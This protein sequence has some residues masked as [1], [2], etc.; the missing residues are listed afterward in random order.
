M[1]ERAKND[2]FV[3]VR[4]VLQREVEAGRSFNDAVKQAA[5][6]ERDAFKRVMQAC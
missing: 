4:D 1:A 6:E 5:T 3:R 2:D